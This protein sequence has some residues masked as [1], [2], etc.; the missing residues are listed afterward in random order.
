[1]LIDATHPA[2]TRVG[3]QAIVLAIVGG[4]MLTV[5]LTRPR[6]KWMSRVTEDSESARLWA[7]R[8]LTAFAFMMGGYAWATLFLVL[9]HQLNAEAAALLRG[10]SVLLIAYAWLVHFEPFVTEWRLRGGAAAGTL[11]TGCAM[12]AASTG[13]TCAEVVR[14]SSVTRGDLWLMSIAVGAATL[15]WA[16]SKGIPRIESS[17]GAG[18]SP[19]AEPEQ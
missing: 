12:L 7:E 15:C 16:L 13:V 14:T 19:V 17:L 2:A 3:G 10:A 18:D 4:T 9:R 6:L 1:M 8:G 11:Y 5:A